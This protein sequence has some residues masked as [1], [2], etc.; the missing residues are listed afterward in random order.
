MSINMKM[1]LIDVNGKKINAEDKQTQVKRVLISYVADNFTDLYSATD[2]VERI[3]LKGY[4]M[5]LFSNGC[6]LGKLFTY[7]V[8]GN[9]EDTTQRIYLDVLSEKVDTDIDFPSA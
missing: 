1:R 7:A 5:S 9:S 6:K 3:E 8:N 2:V 4:N